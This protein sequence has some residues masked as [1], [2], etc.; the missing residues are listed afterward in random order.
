MGHTFTRL[1]LAGGIAPVNELCHFEA[2]E[3][4]PP[5]FLAPPCQAIA[6]LS[7]LYAANSICTLKSLVYT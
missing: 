4:I 2:A 3:D 6:N 1:L 7:C 5:F